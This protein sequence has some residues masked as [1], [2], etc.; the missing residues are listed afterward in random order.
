MQTARPQNNEITCFATN[1]QTVA[2]SDRFSGGWIHFD[3]R[4]R[5]DGW[6]NLRDKSD[7]ADGIVGIHWNKKKKL[8]NE[9]K[10]L[11]TEC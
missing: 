8:C 3:N 1:T 6:E 11:T 9:N 10:I 2:I 5:I 7:S 4:N